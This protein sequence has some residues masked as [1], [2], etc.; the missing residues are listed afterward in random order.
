MTQKFDNS[1]TLGTNRRKEKDSHP[2]HSGQALIDGKPY[3]IS[4]WIK[5]GKDGKFFS[6]AFKPKEAKADAPA[7]KK[8]EDYSDEIPF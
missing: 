2:S 7:A 4:A 8:A 5:E 1:G 6:L 3:W